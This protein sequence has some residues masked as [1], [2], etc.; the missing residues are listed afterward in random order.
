[1]TYSTEAPD[2]TTRYWLSVVSRE[3]VQHAVD[4]G[5]AQVNHGKKTPLQRMCPGDGLVYYSPRERMGDGAPIKSF[6][7]IGTIAEGEPWQADEGSFQPWRRTVSYRGDVRQLPIDE[8]RS[9]LDLTSNPNYG[10]I[11][12]RGLV[13]LSEHDFRS[14]SDAMGGRS[15]P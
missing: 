11:L 14:I 7:A 13:E 6:T 2:T 15:E 5:I 8:L 3:H 4:L 12:R 10:M 1:M 9:V